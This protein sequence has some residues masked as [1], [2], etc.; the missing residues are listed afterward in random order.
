MPRSNEL[1]SRISIDSMV[2]ASMA[3]IYVNSITYGRMGVIAIESNYSYE[4][5]AGVYNSVVKKLFKKT[6][7]SVTQHEINII[8][9]STISIYIIGGSGS[10]GSLAV[11]GYNSLS[12]IITNGDI[13]PSTNNPGMPIFFSMRYLNDFSPV[14]FTY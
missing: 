11:V 8:N 12:S 2:T 4:E 9:E 6:S 1:I 3:P 7:E 5:V 13:Q 14:T 10:L